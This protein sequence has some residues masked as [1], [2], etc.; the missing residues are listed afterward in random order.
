MKMTDEEYAEKFLAENPPPE[1][2]AASEWLAM[3]P[4]P[5]PE[6]NPR[7]Y[8]PT[9]QFGLEIPMEEW[10]TSDLGMF[11]DWAKEWLIEELRKFHHGE[12][13]PGMKLLEEWDPSQ[14]REFPRE[15]NARL[16]EIAQEMGIVAE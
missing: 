13:T 3:N 16:G 15:A 10:T 2:V 9:D 6:G 14:I 1:G 12:T 4:P 8:W 11:P 5:E 7:D